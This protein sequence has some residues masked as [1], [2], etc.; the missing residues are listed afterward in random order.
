MNEV[1][2][3]RVSVDIQ[4][5]VDDFSKI[6]KGFCKDPWNTRWIIECKD[7]QLNFIRSWTGHCVFA[8]EFVEE[9]DGVHF[10]AA[11][12]CRD[13]AKYRGT[14]DADD[15]ATI[16]C[17]IDRLLLGRHVSLPKIT[18]TESTIKRAVR[19]WQDGLLNEECENEDE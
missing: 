1:L 14:N 4:Y 17:L 15:L 5:S 3:K 6:K 12:L 7:K 9:N 11:V 13:P 10:H 18:E 19:Y 8:L 2:V 16:S